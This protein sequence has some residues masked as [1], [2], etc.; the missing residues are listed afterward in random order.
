[1]FCKFDLFNFR[2]AGH[3]PFSEDSNEKLFEII[4]TAKYDF[5]S[6]LFE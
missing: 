1:M 6:P 5:S 3:P 4:K 2:L